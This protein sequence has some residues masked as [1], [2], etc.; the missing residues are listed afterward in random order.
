MAIPT[1]RPW[2]KRW[3]SSTWFYDVLLAIGTVVGAWVSA[4]FATSDKA[5]DGIRVVGTVIAVV[6]IL[7]AVV[8]SRAQHAKESVTDLA[9]CIYPLHSMLLVGDGSDVLRVTIHV[10]C[11]SGK[12]LEQVINYVGGGPRAGH[13]SG[14]KFSTRA[15]A[16]GEAFR[17]GELSCGQ[18]VGTDRE[19]HVKDLVSQY[20]YSN[21]EARDLNPDCR[22]WAAMPI[23][24]TRQQVQAVLYADSVDP[25]FFTDERLEMI[26]YAAVG[27]A[28]YV[29][30]RYI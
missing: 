22:A 18:W 13:G 11:D 27:I 16:I 10:P 25:E 26:K 21:K 15:G 17:T 28:Y 3:L 8:V 9:A 30:E 5:A 1:S 29:G 14:R 12:N 6:Q 19:R 24:D 7:K 4:Q 20:G 2:W 23:T